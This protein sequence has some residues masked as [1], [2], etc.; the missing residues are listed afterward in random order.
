MVS[1]AT[2]N[3]VGASHDD[4]YK[5][6]ALSN[7]TLAILLATLDASITIIA[8]PDIFRGIH[9]DPLLPS[10]SF[11]LLWMI[12]GYLVVTSVLIVSLGRL[13]DMYGRVRIYT[14]GFVIYTV[15]SLMLAIDWLTGTDGALFLIVFRIVQGIGGA[16]LLANS[17]AILTDA[18][19]ANQRGM[20]LGINNIVGVS[21]M[22][23]GLV[24][25][26]L[27]APIDW[28]LVFLISVPVGLFG[29]VWAFLKL[30]ELSTPNPGKIDW[31][32]NVTF[33]LGLIL[34][35]VAVTFGIRPYGGSPTGWGSPL[36]LTLLALAALSLFA[37]V[38]IERRVEEPMFRLPLFRIRAF[39]FGT[40]STFLAAVARGGLM[41]MLIIWLQGIWLPLHG[42][43][44]T[45]APLLAGIYMLPLTVGMLIAGPTSGYL[46]DRFGARGFAT[47][48]MVAAAASFAALTLLPVDFSYPVFA[49]I[50]AFNGISMGM[51]ASPNRAAV[52][53]SLPPDARGA[54]GGMNQTFQNSAQVI[55]M[56]IFF[57]LLII[58]L[59][60][61]LP[62]TLSSGLEAHGVSAAKAH[63]AGETP[64]ISVLFAAFLGE[65][66]IEHLVGASTLH[67]L[68]QHAQ[69]ALT[70][71][72]FFPHLISQPFSNGLDTAFAFAIVACLIAA[73][74]SLMRGGRYTHTEPS[75]ATRSAAAP[76]IPKLEESHAR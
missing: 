49:A 58:G 47:G 15:A 9:L 14:L 30:K 36:V 5:W 66:P 20:A 69:A 39:T 68:P 16:C 46:S 52:M 43:D 75:E 65:N 45:E 60:A 41:F 37:F 35:M 19:P 50:L 34:A 48:G 7:T 67:E 53:N 72:E 56:G 62:H 51:F 57:T 40:L 25:G 23:V 61:S 17:A 6:V 42:Y 29:T 11:Y 3:G 13:G 18:F 32:G 8:M 10:N 22:F 4:R 59:A 31:W 24:L 64:P 2:A 27:L 26:G 70:G 76:P 63:T 28:R 74:A 44:Y 71:K 21:G 12:L 73:G 33:A 55:S 54:G 1:A 38:Q